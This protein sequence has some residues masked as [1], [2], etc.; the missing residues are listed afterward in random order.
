MGSIKSKGIK[1]RLIIENKK[2]QRV[3]TWVMLR[4]K[5]K[6]RTNPKRRNWRRNKLKL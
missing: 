4:T 6:V 5:M 3:P 2:A 1:R